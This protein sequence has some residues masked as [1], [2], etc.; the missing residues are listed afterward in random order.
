MEYQI[1][2]LQKERHNL[3]NLRSNDQNAIEPLRSDVEN[4][5]NALEE[6]CAKLSHFQADEIMIGQLESQTNTLQKERNELF[7]F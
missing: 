1:N 2:S 7:N 3:L 5:K 6:E 4:R